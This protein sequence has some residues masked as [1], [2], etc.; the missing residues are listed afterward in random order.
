MEREYSIQENNFCCN[1]NDFLGSNKK[2]L[3][4]Q[5][6]STE[7][8]TTLIKAI[9]TDE[10][11][12]SDLFF[13]VSEPEQLLF[14]LR[15]QQNPNKR[16]A[17]YG[18]FLGYGKDNAHFSYG[19]NPMGIF[20]S[21]SNA[22]RKNLVYFE[23]QI[24]NC[25]KKLGGQVA[26]L[27]YVDDDISDSIKMLIDNICN[28][29]DCQAKFICIT[30]KQIIGGNL[31]FL[32]KQV[33]TNEL[34]I[35]LFYSADQVKDFF[36]L[37]NLKQVESLLVATNENIYEMFSI[38]KQICQIDNKESDLFIESLIESSLGQTYS[39][40]NKK[41]LGTAAHL[42]AQFSTQELH[43]ICTQANITDSFEAVDEIL[44][45]SRKKGVFSCSSEEYNFLSKYIKSVFAKMQ[46]RISNRLHSAIAE[47][48]SAYNPFAYH[49]RRLHLANAGDL[50]GKRNMIAME[51]CNI[52]HFAKQV[53]NDASQAFE[54]EFGVDAKATMLKVYNAII[55]GKYNDAQQLCITLATVD[56]QIIQQE[57]TYLNAL[58]DWKTGNKN[59]LVIAKNNLSNII[60]SETSE[61]EMVIL[62]KMLLLSIISN[63]GEYTKIETTDTPEN[64]FNSIKTDISKYKHIDADFLR[65]ILYRKSNAAKQRVYSINLVKQS[66]EFFNERKEIY[67]DEYFKAGTNLLALGLQ[68]L[69]A[70]N[71]FAND[72]STLAQTLESDSETNL[73]PITI[74]LYLKNNLLLYKL[75]CCPESIK[76]SDIGVFYN[77][78]YND[79]DYVNLDSRILFTMNVG[80]F[81][82]YYRNYNKARQ[83]WDYAEKLNVINDEYFNYIIYTNRI[84]CDICE[85][86]KIAELELPSPAIFL[87]DNEIYQ[88]IKLRNHLI[89]QLAKDNKSLTYD[90][91]VKLFSETFNIQFNQANLLFYSN[92]FLFSEIQFWS[93]N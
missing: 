89:N 6:K 27:L 79:S 31:A 91:L 43:K 80:T 84:I 32:Q 19:I 82:A 83:F 76:E 53:D 44:E 68:S 25:I 75:F 52:C 71:L 47:Y 18:Y 42:Y 28:C 56:N 33:Y 17:E 55:N 34:N 50:E 12:F 73:L 88:Y 9:Q 11:I 20:Y 77:E 38:Y 72:I 64:I 58:I 49:L 45:E 62:S 74:K 29:K 37:L 78:F 10:Y 1:V 13:N 35:Q 86:K 24:K 36:P 67:A 22:F 40:L 54:D 65:Y 26:I 69:D 85:G 21:L 2:L 16:P 57:C 4:I 93:D 60:Q 14:L 48:L 59:R 61:P 87:N 63:I 90:Q 81:F 51:M 15:Q 3:I 5:C 23:D 7:N 92:P 41:I 30:S 8:C 66:F 46:S 70:S 39:E